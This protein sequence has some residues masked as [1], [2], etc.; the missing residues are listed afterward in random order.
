MKNNIK[1][2]LDFIKQ[3]KNTNLSKSVEQRI[4]I[5]RRSAEAE[6]L[7]K[8]LELSDKDIKEIEEY[9]WKEIRGGF[10]F[11]ALWESDSYWN[12][13][14]MAKDTGKNWFVMELM[15]KRMMENP[16]VNHMVAKWSVSGQMTSILTT[17]HQVLFKIFLITGSDLTPYFRFSTAESAI[18][19]NLPGYQKHQKI[20]LVAIDNEQR[21][22]GITPN[23]GQI[24]IIHFDEPLELKSRNATREN[25]DRLMEKIELIT[26]SGFDRGLKV[27]E[28]IKLIN[29][30]EI[31]KQ[32]KKY[33]IKPK[34][35]F[36]SNP[37]ANIKHELI[38]QIIEG[39]AQDKSLIDDKT[40]YYLQIVTDKKWGNGLGKTVVYGSK[41]INPY[42]SETGKLR[43]KIR[44]KNN[45]ALYNAID[46]GI[47]EAL[48]GE[49]FGADLKFIIKKP[50]GEM[51]T[52]D[53]FVGG[54]DW[55]KSTRHDTEA[56]ILGFK[57]NAEISM[58]NWYLLD[59]VSFKGK[60]QDD[61]HYK[62]NK[63]R[64]FFIEGK[65]KFGY[66]KLNIAVDNQSASLKDDM[67]YKSVIHNDHFLYWDASKDDLDLRLKN[68]HGK[69]V[70]ETIYIVPSLYDD[71]VQDLQ[72][73][74]IGSDGRPKGK[75]HKADAAMYGI[76]L[77]EGIE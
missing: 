13:M 18:I 9:L 63:I 53:G 77:V 32:L 12:A 44:K 1:I 42:L 19:F 65:T 45:K 10:P 46:L 33:V 26:D 50:F 24:E 57:W 11:D 55:A 56:F 5:F 73:W 47:L 31:I 8:Q 43:A 41:F 62:K 23:I 64:D 49:A 37:L 40:G 36:T 2:Y 66:Q 30:P 27:S 74:T 39:A 29:D 20:F 21:V 38:Q 17:L 68:L 54:V 4:K 16:F 58:N 7:I 14:L 15:I 6:A 61:S 52:M 25:L 69:I 75:D 34:V 76:N 72:S 22:Q 35:F 60:D 71:F 48:S 3:Q 70:L 59:N 51:P 28:M 67:N